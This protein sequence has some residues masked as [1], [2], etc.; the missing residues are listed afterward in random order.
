M[1]ELIKRTRD[2]LV[3]YTAP[4]FDAFPS[5]KHAFFTRHGGRST[6]IFD[7]LNFRFVGGDA[8]ENVL[9][10]YGIA[11][12][13]F[14][15]TQDSIVTTEQRHT[16]NIV[17]VTEPT[18]L[19]TKLGEG[20]DAIMT[21][22]P[23]V[24]LVGFYAD[25]QLLMF[26]DKRNKAAAVCH[27]GWRGVQNQIVRKTIEKMTSRYET[28]PSDLMVAVSPS[29]CRR[30][31][32]TDEDVPELLIESYGE[33]VRENMYLEGAKWHVDLKSITYGL[34]LRSG[35]LPYN[36]DVSNI[37]PCCDTTEGMFWSHRKH[38]EQRGVH[39]G[40]LLLV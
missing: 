34:L 38:G 1:P 7:S 17:E 32:E 21:N 33:T 16:D 18:G 27:A 8:K 2:E 20:I 6:G 24:I 36:I 14:G 29:I 5:V 40:Y 28:R 3:Y 13:L 25:C 12:S 35:V 31:F 4:Q 39:A 11:A 9:K 30:C 37:C 26:Y 10:N 19:S 22:K 23:G 15:K